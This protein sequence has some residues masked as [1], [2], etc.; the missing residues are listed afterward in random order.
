MDVLCILYYQLP[1]KAIK[2][3]TPKRNVNNVLVCTGKPERTFSSLVCCVLICKNSHIRENTKNLSKV[4]NYGK[5][6]SF[7]SLQGCE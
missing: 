3:V 1:V 5:I 2:V 7:L 6:K 4:P